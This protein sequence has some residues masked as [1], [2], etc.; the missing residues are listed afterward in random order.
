M[1]DWKFWEAFSSGAIAAILT[2]FALIKGIA[3]T[4]S[5]WSNRAKPQLLDVQNC[6]IKIESGF[7]PFWFELLVNNA[8]LKDCSVISVEL[9]LPNGDVSKLVWASGSTRLPKTITAGQAVLITRYGQCGGVAQYGKCKGKLQRPV[10]QPQ[11]NS[12]E[13]AIVVKFN[14]NKIIEKKTIFFVTSRFPCD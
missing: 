6:C 9:R 3:A 8:G 4:K 14:T 1:V 7:E 5:L 13:G 2:V 10:L 11:N 12:I